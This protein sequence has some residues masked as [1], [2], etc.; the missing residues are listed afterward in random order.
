MVAL[1]L[2]QS[3]HSF[4]LFVCVLGGVLVARARGRDAQKNGTSKARE[5][6]WLHA[7]RALVEGQNKQEADKAERQASNRLVT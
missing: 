5:R 2:A 3:L 7:Q 4:S 6:G 1:R